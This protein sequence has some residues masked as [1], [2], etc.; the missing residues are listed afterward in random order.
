LAQ[1]VISRQRSKRSLLGVERTSSQVSEIDPKA[2][3]V[4]P[5]LL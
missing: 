3:I 1:S 2:D 5:N 4:S